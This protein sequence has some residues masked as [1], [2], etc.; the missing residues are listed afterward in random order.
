MI[1]KLEPNNYARVESLF[2][3]MHD[4]LTVRAMLAGKFLG[5]VYVDDPLSP[6]A[7]IAIVARRRFFL[8]G[9]A[10]NAQFN[11]ALQ[12]FFDETVYPQAIQAG[13]KLLG[14]YFEPSVWT[15]QMDVILKNKNPTQP[16]RHHFLLKQLNHNWRDLLPSDFSIRLVD[17]AL[18]ADASIRGLDE[19]AEEMQ[20]ERPS[21]DEFLDQGFGVCLIHDN[22]IAGFCLS[23]YNV[24]DACEVGIMTHPAFRK[25][26]LATAMASAFIEHA[27]THGVTDIGWHCYASNL[28]SV[29]TAEKVGF[30][31][32]R[33][34]T[35]FQAWYDKPKRP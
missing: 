1:F 2:A 30:E 4:H 16:L 5:E 27:R 28:A 11:F 14:L 20:S 21:V 13:K 18:L 17:R 3:P 34:Y 6:R 23:E 8:A 22:A 7:G 24:G 19:L 35:I 33:D 29:A 32:V 12:N 26:G 25:R 10:H 9:D 31:K 15:T